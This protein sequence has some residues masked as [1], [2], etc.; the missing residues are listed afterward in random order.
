MKGKSMHAYIAASFAQTHGA[1]DPTH[2]PMSRNGSLA[3]LDRGIAKAAIVG[4]L[5]HPPDDHRLA[6]VRRRI[7]TLESA[8]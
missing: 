4:E 1:S 5:F 2:Q 6:A 8:S 3:R 7:K